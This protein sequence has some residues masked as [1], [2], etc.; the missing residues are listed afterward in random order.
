M[1]NP[2][3]I[4]VGYRADNL[5]PFSAAPTQEDAIQRAIALKDTFQ[6]VEV[7]FM[8]EDD[9]DTNDLVYSSIS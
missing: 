6:C 4:F 9:L 1:S 3:V 8:P 5:Q 2:Y 7:V